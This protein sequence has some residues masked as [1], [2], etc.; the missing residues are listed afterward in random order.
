MPLGKAMKEANRRRARYVVIVLPKANQVQVK[1]FQ[2]GD[3]AD[4]T[5]EELLANPRTYLKPPR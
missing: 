1:D 5:M 3:A 2:T 4:T